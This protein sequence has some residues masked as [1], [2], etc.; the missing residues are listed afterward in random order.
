MKLVVACATQLLVSC[1]SGSTLP[2]FIAFKYSSNEAS[3]F[4]DQL[5]VALVVADSSLGLFF[6]FP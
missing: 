2:Y 6:D 4:V 3:V 1:H 5:L